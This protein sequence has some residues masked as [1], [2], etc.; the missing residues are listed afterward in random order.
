MLECQKIVG[1]KHPFRSK[2]KCQKFSIIQ[3][4]F[5][6]FNTINS[7]QEANSRTST[8]LDPGFPKSS[9]I[10]CRHRSL[11]TFVLQR[12]LK[13]DFVAQTTGCSP[14][15]GYAADVTSVI[16]LGLENTPS[17]AGEA[18]CNLFFH[19]S[20]PS[21][22]TWC[23]RRSSPGCVRFQPLG[24]TEPSSSR[25]IKQTAV[26]STVV[27]KPFVLWLLSGGIIVKNKL[28]LCAAFIFHLCAL[29]WV[30]FH[31]S[32][33]DATTQKIVALALIQAAYCWEKQPKFQMMLLKACTSNTSTAFCSMHTFLKPRCL[34]M[35]LHWCL[36]LE[37]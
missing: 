23:V 35:T 9:L 10:E 25:W 33:F 14:R 13:S 17:R 19:S 4:Y 21:D 31:D 1:V 37:G 27:W 8:A 30:L 29:C 24:V 6:G 11:N 18:L 20:W 28:R 34:W 16:W 32:K 15:A 2:R 5:I 12:F 22:R 36:L 3:W 26:G 7:I